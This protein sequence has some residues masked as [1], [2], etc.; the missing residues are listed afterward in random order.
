MIYLLK[1]NGTRATLISRVANVIVYSAHHKP[2]TH[3]QSATVSFLLLLVTELLL[4]HVFMIWLSQR[5]F[6][7]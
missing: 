4:H 3:V 6:Q 2:G 5:L 7:P 1:S